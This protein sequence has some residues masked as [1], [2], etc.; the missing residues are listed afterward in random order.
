MKSVITQ[1]EWN[2]CRFLLMRSAWRRWRINGRGRH[3]FQKHHFAVSSNTGSFAGPRPSLRSS[4]GWQMP[5]KT[6]PFFCRGDPKNNYRRWHPIDKGQIRST[7][8]ELR[9]RNVTRE[10]ESL[11]QPSCN[12]RERRKRMRGKIQIYMWLFLS[13]FVTKF[14]NPGT[15]DYLFNA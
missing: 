14:L 9:P 13:C 8:A 11:I 2:T 5:D 1:V 12:N 6:G 3:Y 10:V 4:S 7:L 15:K